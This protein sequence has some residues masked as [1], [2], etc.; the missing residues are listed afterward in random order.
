MPMFR[1]VLLTASAVWLAF[2]AYQCWLTWPVVPLDVSPDDPATIAAHRDA[3]MAHLTLW[4][5]YGLV[6][7]AA[8][9]MFLWL[10][11]RLSRD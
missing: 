1:W 11:R 4:L 6:P 9:W 7:A 10:G 8:A 2:A 5:L 3:T